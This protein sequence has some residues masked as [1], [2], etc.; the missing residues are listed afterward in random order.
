MNPPLLAVEGLTTILHLPSGPAFAVDGIDLEVAEGETL[1]IVGESGCGKSMLALSLIGLQ[2]NPP[3]EVVAGRAL[4][5]GSDLLAQSSESLRAIRGS[6]IGMIFQEPMSALNPVMKIGEQ[7]AEVCRRH[8]RMGARAAW[9]RAVELL[10]RV[11]IPDPST[12]AREYPFQLSGGLRQRVMIASALACGPAMLIADEPTTALDVTIQAQILDLIRE[13]Q[14]GTGMAVILITHDL[15]VIAETADRVMVMYAGR[16]IEEASADRLFAGPR[17]PY[18][19]GL[20]SS[21]PVLGT[22]RSSRL[23]EIGGAVPTLG[24]SVDG[25]AFEPRC[26]RKGGLCSRKAPLLAPASADHLAACH[27]PRGAP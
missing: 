7:I 27:F 24:A 25:C 12:R 6:R 8:D 2:P 9:R 11:G 1:G 10:E 18:T 3:A 22:S 15:G 21:V 4:F 16:K 14:T 23:P 5:E 19:H 20:L 13:L 17:H 26:D